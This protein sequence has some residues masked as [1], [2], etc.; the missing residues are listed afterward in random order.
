MEFLKN[1]G[2]IWITGL[3]GSGKS[4]IAEALCKKLK[5]KYN[6]I[7][8][9]DGDELR[10]LLGY[11]GYDKQS[12]I[13]MSIKRSKFAH[14]LSS[15]NMLVIVSTISMW[16]EI[17]EY[18]KKTLKNYFEVYI[19]CDF[20]ELKRRDKKNLYSKT[21]KGEI[22]NVVGID[23]AFDEPKSNLIIDNTHMIEL[24]NKISYILTALK[25]PKN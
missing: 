4:Y 15:Q 8:Y 1:G 18:N 21:L 12:R 6:N 5:E 13:E 19:K 22:S 17:Y 16:N 25:I 2:V 23:I 7:I 20:E 3:A 24:D 9:L 11:Y 10:D 14:F